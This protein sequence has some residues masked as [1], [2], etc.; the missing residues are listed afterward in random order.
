MLIRLIILLF[1]ALPVCAEDI[2][3]ESGKIALI[4]LGSL[5]NSEAQIVNKELVRA[6]PISGLEDENSNSVLALQGLKDSGETDLTVST[7]SGFYQFRVILNNQKTTDLVINPSSSR[8][9]LYPESFHLS[10]ERSSI[11][12]LPRYI[13]QKILVGD[14]ELIKATQF[15]DYYDENFLKLISIT[16]SENKGQTSLVIPSQ[17]GV[18][19]LNIDVNKEARH[20]ANINLI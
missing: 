15:L 19:K 13:N 3:L 12:S 9:K 18:Y 11:V 8:L 10:P 4:D 6:Y 17:T 5:I 2:Y 1:L 14:P 16:S 7:S 20:E